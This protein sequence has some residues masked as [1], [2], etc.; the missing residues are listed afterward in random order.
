M[1]MC[2]DDCG[3]FGECI[4]NVC[5]CRD[6]W[7][8]SFDSSFKL[9]TNFVENDELFAT[10]PCI[11]NEILLKS[12]YVLS[13]VC[14]VLALI[15]YSL[16][17]SRFSQFKR[18]LPLFLTFLGTQAMVIYKMVKFDGRSV[19]FGLD[20][21]LS[22]SIIL[23]FV[24]AN[25]VTAIFLN[26]YLS[27]YTQLDLITNLQAKQQYIL[28][29]V[30]T[31]TFA[32]LMT[33]SLFITNPDVKVVVFKVGLGL[34]TLYVLYVI[35]KVRKV[36]YCF[37]GKV[38]EIS[39]INPVKKE[40]IKRYFR[41]IVYVIQFHFL[42]TFV[43]GVVSLSSEPTLRLFIYF[44]P[45]NIIIGYVSSILTAILGYKIR[46]D[47]GPSKKKVKTLDETK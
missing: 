41:C 24:G 8:N 40:T 11:E 2:I 7:K 35:Y 19:V 21:Y 23:G 14:S 31:I 13:G 9:D 42:S 3:L 47:K 22:V 29:T 38:D 34:N 6:G 5:I 26:K 12:L 30:V 44:G 37:I 43:M 39:G 27:Y 20:V 16:S 28:M 15:V 1:N 46:K 10:L 17:V 45:L 18:L 33:T 4:D 25:I 32:S 36:V